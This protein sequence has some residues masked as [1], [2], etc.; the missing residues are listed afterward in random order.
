MSTLGAHIAGALKAVRAVA[1]VAIEYRRGNKTCP[2]AQATLGKRQL[3]TTNSEGIV[4][5][6][7]SHSFMF[8]VA[9]LVLDSV[10]AI[11]QSGDKIVFTAG[12]IQFTY[13][14]L[15]VDYGEPYD[16]SDMNRT[17]FRVHTLAEAEEPQ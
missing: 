7:Q 9:D 1:G 14:V 6:V 17:Q 3:T 2:I 11:P 4:T 15:P 13:R 16:Y 12:G 8:A 5:V 10:Q